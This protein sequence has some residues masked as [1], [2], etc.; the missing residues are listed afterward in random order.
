LVEVIGVKLRMLLPLAAMVVAGLSVA[1]ASAGT[2]VNQWTMYHGGPTHQ[3]LNAAETV[4]NTTSAPNLKLF[5]KAPTG[6]NIVYSS[7]AVAGGVVYLGSSDG[8]LYAFDERSGRQLWTGATGGAVFSSPAVG[9]GVV[10]AGS[11]DGR[12]YAF[13]AGGCGR[14]SCAPLWTGDTG[15]IV[16]S[17]PTLA[18]GRVFIGSRAEDDA[19]FVF[20]AAGCGAPTCAPVAVDPAGETD[21][22]PA[23]ANGVAYH[24]AYDAYLYAFS[25]S[26]SGAC[27]P[28]WKFGTAAPIDSSP[29]VVNGTVYV[30]SA[31]ARIY[32]V[33]ATTGAERWHFMTGLTT[34]FSS[35]AVA[36]G[37]VYIG[38]WDAGMYSLDSQTGQLAWR[39]TD[40]TGFGF[41]S[42]AVAGGVVFADAYQDGAVY[43]INAATGLPLWAGLAGVNNS[44]SPA[45]ADGT[46]FISSGDGNL[47]AFRPRATLPLPLPIGAAL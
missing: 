3:G 5:W 46:L 6:G 17:S 18:G 35:P 10:Y 42:P 29:A 1:P 41:S 34:N 43:A 19:M 8:L 13:A 30:G 12:L 37:R 27:A 26:C 44:S 14:T 11:G 28:L 2:L 20:N 15:G 36:Y 23:V 25:A 32:A 24:S 33:N 39:F 40:P 9:G 31:D 16:V 47:Y 38:S 7:P 4:I 22:T 21:S 45:V